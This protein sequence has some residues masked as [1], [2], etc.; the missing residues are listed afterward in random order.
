MKYL[1][2]SALLLVLAGCGTHMPPGDWK[3]PWTAPMS[4][5]Q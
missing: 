4:I 1:V 3:D 5:P 2:I